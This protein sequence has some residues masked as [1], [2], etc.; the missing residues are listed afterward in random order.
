MGINAGVWFECECGG[1][2]KCGWGKMQLV[3]ILNISGVIG[4]PEKKSCFAMNFCR[5]LVSEF[6]T[7]VFFC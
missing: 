4:W 5:R 6:L 1:R 3:A 7:I 2:D